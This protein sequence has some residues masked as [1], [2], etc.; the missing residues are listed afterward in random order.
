MKN[1]LLLII[2][3]F[4]CYSNSAQT[5]K[6][7]IYSCYQKFAKLNDFKAD[8]NIKFDV[9]SINIENTKGKILYKKPNKFRVRLSG[10]AFLPKQNPFDNFNVM[11]DT[12]AYVAVSMGTETIGKQKLEVINIIPTTS[13]SDLI[14]GKFWINKSQSLIHQYEITT[15][16][17]GTMMV[18]QTFAEHVNFALP[19]SIKFVFDVS[20]FKIPKAI[21]VD[22]NA[23]KN[24]KVDNRKNGTITMNLSNY[25]INKKIKDEEFTK[26]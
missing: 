25:I 22:I 17:S 12:S 7:I 15:R 5:P 18:Y 20:K 14:S 9:P 6:A 16:K 19:N 3:T 8:A 21:A 2:I 4:N 1:L 23:D 10:I 24:K 13:N 26:D 11:A